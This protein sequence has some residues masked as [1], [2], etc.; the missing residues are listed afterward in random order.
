METGQDFYSKNGLCSLWT[1]LQII[2]KC[3]S[4]RKLE[5]FRAFWYKLKHKKF[6][7][8]SSNREIIF[9]FVYINELDKRGIKV[10][11]VTV[12]VKSCVRTVLLKNQLKNKLSQKLRRKAFEN[13]PKNLIDFS[14]RVYV[15]HVREKAL[16]KSHAFIFLECYI[17][18][19]LK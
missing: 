12:D 19:L 6:K 10:V 14:I 8:I 13:S 7:W 2:K 4:S 1:V 5:F 16:N 9:C 3:A 18:K 15:R 17:D 11:K